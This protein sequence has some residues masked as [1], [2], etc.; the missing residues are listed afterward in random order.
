VVDFVQPVR[1]E[2]AW[3][4]TVRLGH[5]LR[6]GVERALRL[7]RLSRRFGQCCLTTPEDNISYFSGAGNKGERSVNQD[8]KAL[9][10][11]AG[12]EEGT[13]LGGCHQKARR[14]SARVL[15]ITNGYPQ[16]RWD[17]ECDMSTRFQR[18]PGPTNFT[19]CRS[20][21]RLSQFEQ[22]GVKMCTAVVGRLSRPF[23]GR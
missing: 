6:L 22:R 13:T 21:R 2:G 15:A 8:E 5:A 3:R 4:T 1:P 9:V 11:G 12:R 16:L 20:G 19:I 23:A 17:M 7:A 14:A 18:R 10:C